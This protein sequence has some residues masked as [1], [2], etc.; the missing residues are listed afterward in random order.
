[1]MDPNELWPFQLCRGH[2]KSPPEGACLLDAVSW[3]EYG[4]LGDEPPCV[5]PVLAFIGHFVN[6][7]ATDAERQELRRFIPKLV[8]TAGSPLADEARVSFLLF[9][10]HEIEQ[11]WGDRAL[12]QLGIAPMQMDVHLRQRDRCDAGFHARLASLIMKY[13]H[14]A[15]RLAR[16]SGWRRPVYEHL[17]L[18]TP[19]QMLP[20]DMKAMSMQAVSYDVSYLE[21][22]IRRAALEALEVGCAIGER[23]KEFDE[24]R[25][26][27]RVEAFKRAREQV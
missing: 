7:T 15:W 16:S 4:C 20:Q 27:A 21:S 25:A 14:E 1:M 6:D 12:K 8:G 2:S 11:V 17:V 19:G 22:D 10:W 5:S 23:R 13:M 24:R 26:P 18:M 9:K 3:F